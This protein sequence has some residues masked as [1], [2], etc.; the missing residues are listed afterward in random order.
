MQTGSHSAYC[1]I[2]IKNVLYC[3]WCRLRCSPSCLLP[4]SIPLLCRG[5]LCHRVWFDLCAS[6]CSSLLAQRL[7]AKTS[8]ES[9][10]HCIDI[11]RTTWISSHSH[12]RG[13]S[14]FLQGNHYRHLETH[15]VYNEKEGDSLWQFILI[16]KHEL[17]TDMIGA[18]MLSCW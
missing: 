5:L 7:T 9:A 11:C 3:Y 4:F 12:E 16:W 18:C 17:I 6:D 13:L 1:L 8:G 2:V 15:G 10:W 14:K